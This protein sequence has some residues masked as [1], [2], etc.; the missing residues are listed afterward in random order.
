MRNLSF[1][2]NFASGKKKKVLQVEENELHCCTEVFFKK[3]KKM[4]VKILQNELAWLQFIYIKRAVLCKA[5]AEM[6]E[7]TPPHN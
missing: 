4:F 2:C 7:L 5:L 1:L 3:K 6:K